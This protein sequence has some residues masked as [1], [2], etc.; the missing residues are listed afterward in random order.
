MVQILAQLEQCKQFPDF[1]NY[2]AFIF[3]QGEALPIEVRDGC[4]VLCAFAGSP[5]VLLASRSA[6]KRLPLTSWTKPKWHTGC[7]YNLLA[8]VLSLCRPGIAYTDDY[9]AIAALHIALDLSHSML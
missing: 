5:V 6:S 7:Q 3:A 4:R 1:N 8:L 2:L 9:C